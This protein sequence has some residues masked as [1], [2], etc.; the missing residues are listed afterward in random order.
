[1]RGNLPPRE[2]MMCRIGKHTWSGWF[3]APV[4]HLGEYPWEKWQHVCLGKQRQCTACG[5]VRRSFTRKSCAGAYVVR[6]PQQPHA[7][8]RKELEAASR[9][10]MEN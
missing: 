5:T 6:L 2:P 4:H 10:L 8:T 9:V 7:P 1:M 3:L